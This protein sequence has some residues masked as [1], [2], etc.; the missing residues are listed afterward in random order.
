MLALLSIGGGASGWRQGR[1][2]CTTPGQH[3]RRLCL[4]LLLLGLAI[5]GL[6]ANRVV[7][8]I[9]PQSAD[10]ALVEFA[11]Q[12]RVS[13]LFP[14]GEFSQ[15]TTRALH[16]EHFVD[17]ALEILLRD[18]GLVAEVNARGS[19]SVRQGNNKGDAGMAIV[20]RNNWFASI[21]SAFSAAL[22]AAPL[23]HGQAADANTATL[24]EVVVTAQRRSERLQDVPISVQALTAQAIDEFG[25]NRSEDLQALVPGMTFTQSL[26]SS[27]PFL[28]GVGS[29]YSAAGGE[30]PVAFYIDDVYRSST[31]AAFFGLHDIQSLE[32]LKGPQGTLFG[33]NATGG[34]VNVTTRD[35]GRTFEGKASVDY[36]NYNRLEGSAYLA[37][38]L[39]DKVAGSLT[40]NSTDRK[41]FGTNTVT[42]NDAFFHRG[43]FYGGKLLFDV[44]NTRL[45]LSADW[46]RDIDQN[47]VVLA[48]FPGSV[49]STTRRAEYAGDYNTTG[50]IDG[51]T[52]NTQYGGSLRTDTDL[53]WGEFRS[54]T[55]YRTTEL[56]LTQDGDRTPTFSQVRKV[57]TQAPAWTEE[58][59]LLS[60]ANARINWI[61]GAFLMDER[62][63]YAFP[64]TQLTTTTQTQ[65]SDA[66]QTTRSYSVFGQATLPLGAKTNLTGG[67]RE[68]QDKRRARD[69]EQFVT[70]AGVTTQTTGAAAQDWSKL[71]WRLALDHKFTP[72]V[73]AYASHS[74]GFKSG[75]FN[76]SPFNALPVNPETL[77]S[78]EVGVKAILF[79]Q[80][81]RINASAYHYDYQD[82][83]VQGNTT[84]NNVTF[85]I[86]FNAASATVNG[87]D[88]DSEFVVTDRFHVRAG[89]A[90][91]DGKYDILR[92]APF[93]TPR[94]VAT[95]GNLVTTQD[96]YGLALFRTP[97]Y[98]ANL[99]AT[100]AVP[101]SVGKITLAAA[102]SYSS[103]YFF[104][105]AHLVS[106][107]ALTMFNASVAW[108][109]RS[110]QWGVRLWGRNLSDQLRFTNANAIAAG[111]V[112]SPGE[113]RT[114]GINVSR[115]FH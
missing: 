105:A 99:L 16:G 88:V 5:P 59:Q 75:L 51:R 66:E 65:Y 42:G 34:V 57:S 80:R 20:K 74:R 85:N 82:M 12:A 24:E 47:G 7:F 46:S 25:A 79:D 112:Y 76:L 54:I 111:N 28:R 107:P 45:R 22:A 32:V 9:P 104:E 40:L 115:A 114:I 94:P 86:L 72:D 81:V 10:R 113:P 13:V 100:Y 14:A 83:Q 49:N 67:L 61:V 18:T 102:G 62:S 63:R 41:G 39:G 98:S 55:A 53:G 92:G 84:I 48:Y 97:K 31:S 4:S 96:A 6:A 43:S 2:A 19:I 17:R 95:G 52:T 103:E 91:V 101:T 29:S 1:E 89:F 27:A 109:D 93:A 44:G 15:V 58:L 78:T 50:E 64:A 56:Y 21:F 69:R 87:F 33:R 106:Q 11:R 70:T 26:A 60:A 68:T 3:V 36:G 30:S 90:M 37:G 108:S 38:P 77:D 71:T 35:P 73:M 8:D 110:E 23:A